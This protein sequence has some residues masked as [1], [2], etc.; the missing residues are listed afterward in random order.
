[1]EL[2]QQNKITDVAA[3]TEDP[4][5]IA[6]WVLEEDPLQAWRSTSGGGTLTLTV[7]EAD[8]LKLTNHNANSLSVTIKTMAD[9]VIHGPVAYDFSALAHDNDSL[10]HGYPYQ[11]EP[12]KIVVDFSDTRSTPAYCG[13]AFAGPRM[14]V[15]GPDDLAE[16]NYIDHSIVRQSSAGGRI[17]TKKAMKRRFSVTLTL[18]WSTVLPEA[19]LNVKNT[20][21]KRCLPWRITDDDGAVHGVFG[22][23]DNVAP[24]EFGNRGVI[25]LEIIER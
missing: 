6:A 12:H 16:I 13:G 18:D 8:T 9:A 2:I 7:A 21:L 25:R 11:A 1:M 4:E 10:W 24:I 22:Y 17:A 14:T 3:N 15:A 20:L 5:Y 23:L 19:I